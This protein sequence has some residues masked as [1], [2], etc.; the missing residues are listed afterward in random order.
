MTP[1]QAARQMQGIVQALAREVNNAELAAL[2][3]GLSEYLGRIFNEGKTTSGESMGGYS[4]QHKKKRQTPRSAIKQRQI[5]TG[6][7]AGQLTPSAETIATYPKNPLQVAF[8]DLQFFGDTFNGVQVGTNA[9][10]N[11]IG[12]LRSA[13]RVKVQGTEDYLRTDVIKFSQAEKE[14]VDTV[15]RKRIDAIIKEA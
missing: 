3:T 5:K 12:F 11:V 8:K 6:P 1:E 2:Q 14:V 9:G 10:N 4:D 15:Y 7:R 13:G